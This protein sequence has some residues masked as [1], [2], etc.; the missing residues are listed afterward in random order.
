MGP[1]PEQL[2]MLC[3]KAKAYYSSPEGRSKYFRSP[4]TFFDEDG[5][6]EDSGVWASREEM[7]ETGERM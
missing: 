6:L 2:V 3:D 7:A 4:N 5:W 1:T